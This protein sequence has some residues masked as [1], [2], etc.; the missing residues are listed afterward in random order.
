[1]KCSPG[2]MRHSFRVYGRLGLIGFRDYERNRYGQAAGICE[3]ERGITNRGD[4]HVFLV[5]F[6][7]Q[8]LTL[9]SPGGDMAC[10]HFF[11][12]F[13]G[14]EFASGAG[15]DEEHLAGGG[16]LFREL[17]VMFVTGEDGA[18]LVRR[19]EFEPVR[20]LRNERV[21]LWA[22]REH[23]VVLNGKAPGKRGFSE[24]GGEPLGLFAG[25][26][27]DRGRGTRGLVAGGI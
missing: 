1:M 23:G 11:G 25:L 14:A 10:G 26:G 2:R 27:I 6:D 21:M 9:G 16:G 8:E 18:N 7:D 3:T 22:G 13:A 24:F 5:E 15:D 19:K 4:F 12:D 17:E 20:G